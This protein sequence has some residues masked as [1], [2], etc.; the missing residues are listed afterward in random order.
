MKDWQMLFTLAAVSR[1]FHSWYLKSCREGAMNPHQQA[2]QHTIVSGYTWCMALEFLSHYSS[3]EKSSM[4]QISCSS[5]D[6]SSLF[7]R[8]TASNSNNAVR[9]FRCM[10]QNSC[11]GG[12][13]LKIS[14]SAC[15]LFS[16]TWVLWAMIQSVWSGWFCKHCT[17]LIGCCSQEHCSLCIVSAADGRGHT[18]KRQISERQQLV[19]TLN[20]H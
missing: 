9:H 8:L 18:S 3:S 20:L 10:P 12:N 16:A 1:W 4:M 11:L 15:D 14:S 17:G 2:P 13:R 19:L 6:N 7:K 5:Q